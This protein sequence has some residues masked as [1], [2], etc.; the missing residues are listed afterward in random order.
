MVDEREPS[1]LDD[2]ECRRHR[3]QKLLPTTVCVEEIELLDVA[4]DPFDLE[5]D[6]RRPADAACSSARLCNNFG[7]EPFLEAFSGHTRRRPCPAM[8]DI[9]LMEPTGRRKFTGFIFKIQANM[10]PAHRDRLAFMRVVQRRV[11]KGHDGVAFRPRTS[12]MQLKQPQQFMA[13]GARSRR[14]RPTRAT[15]S[16]CSTPASSAWATRLSTGPQA[17]L[18]RPF[19]CSRPSILLPGTAPRTA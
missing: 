7:V 17:A 13:A 8:S 14:D 5:A 16:A 9:G 10:N 12:N 4:G 19:R 18:F 1:P 3:W 15:S 11:R 2:P 6:T